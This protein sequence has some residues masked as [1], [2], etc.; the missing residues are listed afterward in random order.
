MMVEIEDRW[1]SVDEI[2]KYLEILEHEGSL[3]MSQ[4]LNFG[5]SSPDPKKGASLSPLRAMHHLRIVPGVG[6][7]GW[8]R[9]NVTH[10]PCVH[11]SE[12]QEFSVHPHEAQAN[13][14]LYRQC[15]RGRF[16]THA[17]SV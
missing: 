12:L 17:S 4:V 6:V 11:G 2:C 1:L 10:K 5:Q 9:V 7:G 14:G 15:I 13:E 3:K 16:L 8:Y